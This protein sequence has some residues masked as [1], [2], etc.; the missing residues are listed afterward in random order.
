MIF[1][2]TMNPSLDR[3]LYVD[4]LKS[5]DTIRVK[6]VNDY[7]AGKGIDVSRVIEELG[8]ETAAISILGGEAG[9]QILYMLQDEG[10]ITIPVWIKTETRTN[11]MIE[12]KSEQF[13]MSLPTYEIKGEDIEMIKE[14]VEKFVKKDTSIVISGSLPNGL[15]SSFYSNIISD[16]KK[17]HIKVYFDADGE[18][19][20]EGLK[21]KPHC[22]KPNLHEFER[23]IDKKLLSK[24]QI[25][26]EG[27][28]ARKNFDL[29]ILLISLGSEGALAFSEDG[30]YECKPLEI[31]VDSSV[32]S[33]DSFLAAFVYYKE[34]LNLSTEESL[35]AANAA[36]AATAMT[37]GTELLHKKDFLALYKKSIV[38][39]VNL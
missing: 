29:G 25:I 19:L 32:G 6:K 18:K 34:Q 14:I 28:K 26:D 20:R 27:I 16:L 35:R 7:P 12:T 3:F 22:I 8:G 10:V 15:K 31:D 2:L 30:V 11:V 39:K 33:G 36:G 4:E 23:L 21:S 5:D 1:S 17:D 38:E 24:T 9:E 13:R 37:P